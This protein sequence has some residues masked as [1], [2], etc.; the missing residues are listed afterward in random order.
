MGLTTCEITW[1][2][3]LLKDMGLN[4]LPPTLLQCDNKA[5]IAIAANP[6]LHKRTKHIEVDCHF[7]RDKIA[8]GVIATRYVPT[9]SQLAD[10]MTKQLSVKQHQYLLNKLGA[11]SA[12]H[13][14]LEGE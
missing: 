8:S 10:V 12:Q 1:I 4:D 13:A 9:H 7:I 2:T 6:V 3:A 11:V 5:V 14:Q